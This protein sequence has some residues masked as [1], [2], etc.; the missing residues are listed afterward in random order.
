MVNYRFIKELVY[1]ALELKSLNIILSVLPYYFR[2][3]SEESNYDISLT[4]LLLNQKNYL[5]FLIVLVVY[6]LSLW[7]RGWDMIESSFSRSLWVNCL[8]EVTIKGLLFGILYLFIKIRYIWTITDNIDTN[9]YFSFNSSKYG[10][11]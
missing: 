5:D 11:L 6:L 2:N 4:L 1:F 10:F 3:N 7:W 8:K 9:N